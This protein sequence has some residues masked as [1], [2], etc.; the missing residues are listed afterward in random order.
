M[1]HKSQTIG[2]NNQNHTHVLRKGEEEFAEIIALYRCISLI[3]FAHFSQTIYHSSRLFAK[4]AS[5]IVALNGRMLHQFVQHCTQSSHTT[6]P[7]LVHNNVNYLK[8]VL[9]ASVVG[10]FLFF[11]I[12]IGTRCEVATNFMNIIFFAHFGSGFQYRFINS[13][14]LRTLVGNYHFHV[15]IV[16]G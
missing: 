7:N 2:K 11:Q 8:H 12:H 14:Q 16:F 9:Q 13:E 3:E 5:H 4:Q 1:A 10:G 15:V 6:K